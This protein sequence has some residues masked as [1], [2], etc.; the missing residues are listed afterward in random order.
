[1]QQ[2]ITR[3]IIAGLLALA[4]AAVHV[5]GSPG[6]TP[7][8]AGDPTPTPTAAQPNGGP[9]GGSGGGGT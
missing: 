2:R 7:A 4:L 3:W 9:G 1:M 6:V 5:Q 8:Y